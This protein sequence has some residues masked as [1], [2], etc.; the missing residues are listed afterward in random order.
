MEERRKQQGNPARAARARKRRQKSRYKQNKTGMFC[1][2]CIVL[3]MLVVMATQILGL[4]R[5]D[6]EYKE[7]EQE[8]TALIEDEQERKEEIVAY[9]QYVTTPEYIEQMA[10]TKLGLVYANE[11]I[12][13]EQKVEE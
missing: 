2:T 8:L 10:K 3:F 5:K 1:I 4:Y 6:Q 12:F 11:I 9:A 13:K 7:R